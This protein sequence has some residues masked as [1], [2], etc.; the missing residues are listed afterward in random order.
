MIKQEKRAYETLD[1]EAILRNLGGAELT[2][3]VEDWVDSTNDAAKR[4]IL[5]GGSTPAVFLAESQT[6]GRGRMGR[7]FYSPAGTGLYLS[8]AVPAEG[9]LHDAVFLTTAAA[10]AVWRAIHRVTG[11]ETRI[12]WVNDLYYMEKKVCGILAESF[13]LGDARFLILGVG[14]NLSTEQ[15]P[16]ELRDRAG[17]LL[18]SSD[19]IR[20]SLAA[21]VI[22][23]LMAVVDG[24][25]DR[26]ALMETYRAC[27]MVLGREIT[28]TE[29]G[30]TR[31]GVAREIDESGRLVVERAD[32]ERA[33]LTSGEIT[34][35][36][37]T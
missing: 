30:V 32:G 4:H 24:R 19:G 9:A 27:S 3:V 36:L 35:R 2:L 22:A 11:I 13:L 29:N 15:F 26:D 16:E 23:E 28:Y 17:S 18:S 34:L 6:A 1:R 31:E 7:S 12:K 25:F 14:I 20:N 5:S 8:L 37:K 33:L 10:V 21:A